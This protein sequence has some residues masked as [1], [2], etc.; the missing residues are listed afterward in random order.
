MNTILIAGISGGAAGALMLFLSHIAPWFGA[1]NFVRDLDELRLFGRTYSRREGHV[2]GVFIH[3][4]LSFFFGALYGFG[5][6][7]GIA[8]GFGVWP[9][10]TYAV[11]LTVF[12]GGVVMPL[13]GHGI[14]G[15]REDDWFP[16]DLLLT[17]LGWVFFYA[18]I[19]TMWLP[20]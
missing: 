6:D 1:G 18:V 9:L 5:V 20:A 13:E 14:F 17:N 4:F 10:V 2:I 11:L 8:S 16:I 19:V 7:Q 3:L 12:V 15:V